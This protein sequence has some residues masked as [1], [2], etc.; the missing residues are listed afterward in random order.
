M[1]SYFIDD[2]VN[3]YLAEV[4]NVRPLNRVE[5]LD[6]IREVRAGSSKSEM[7][8][9]RLVEANLSLVVSIAQRYKDSKLHIL[10]LIQKGNE[11]LLSAL[12]A[13]GTS[14]EDDFAAIAT[15]HV[16]DAIAEALTDAGE[17]SSG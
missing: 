6:C 17:Q 1:E 15:A 9:K 3:C 4:D 11:G 10:D 8:G 14:D 7:A 13:L 5:E 12:R 2:P 16:Q